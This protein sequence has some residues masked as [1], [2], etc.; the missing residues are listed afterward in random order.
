MS[1]VLTDTPSPAADVQAHIAAMNLEQL[2]ARRA[3]VTA[4]T[5]EIDVDLRRRAQDYHQNG[6]STP[7]GVRKG[8]ELEQAEMKLEKE[9]LDERLYQFKAAAK[10]LRLVQSHACLLEILIERGMPE[11]A[12]DAE[13]RACGR[14]AGLMEGG[15]A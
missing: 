8:L 12:A 5:L 7:L 4:R 15:A 11:L 10:H 1:A 3:V 14:L 13:R 9:F 6:V 2:K